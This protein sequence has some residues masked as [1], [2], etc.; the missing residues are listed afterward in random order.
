VQRQ[1]ELLRDARALLV[2]LDMLPEDREALA[3]V[4]TALDELFLL[5]IVGEYNAGKS[6]LI[7]A[8]LGEPAL[9]V[10]D[11]PTTREVHLLKHGEVRSSVQAEEGLLHHHLPAELLRDLCIVDTPGTNSMQRR[12]QELTEH[13]VPRAD[14]VLFLTTLVRPYTASEHDFL[15]YI[16]DW[17]KKILFVVNHADV[18]REPDQIERVRDYV[19]EQAARELDEAP[20]VF[21]VSAREALEGACGPR[22]EWP[23]LETHLKETLSEKERVRLKLRSPLETLR[24]VLVRQREALAER[25]RLVEGDRAAMDRILVDVDEYERRMG[26]ELNRYQSAVDNILLQLERRGHRFLDDTVRLGNILRLRDSD[27]LENRFRHDVIGDAPDRVEEEINALID[28]LVRENLA[29]WDRARETVEERQAALRE[30]AERTRFVPRETV[31]NR[32]EIFR[33]LAGP[34]KKHLRSFDARSEADRVVSAVNDAIART[35]GV[36]ALVVG[37][38]AVLTAAFTSLTIDVTGTI[39]GTLLV[40]AGLFL[41]PHRRARLKRE[42]TTKVETLRTE[43]AETIDRCFRDE[44]RRYAGQLRDVFRPELEATLAR[45]AS[46]AEAA[47]R[48]GELETR[49]ERI[50]EEAAGSGSA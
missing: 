17:G 45:A 41:L 23:A 11:L 19:K 28:W 20:P 32:E 43:L 46:L 27:V 1:R 33:N 29:A 18:A 9:E 25:R 7:N 30:A 6:T 38:G 16:R 39:G 26:Q 4:E 2:D 10:G 14:L 22:N 13:F 37:A 35:L 21:V 8:L 36:E 50:E 24:T 34:V 49:R 42:L 47:D 40:V 15:S 31:Y 3:G 12:E 44:V 5:V 48:L